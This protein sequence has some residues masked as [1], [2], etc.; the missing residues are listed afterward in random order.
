VARSRTGALR[1]RRWGQRPVVAPTTQG[2]KCK[3]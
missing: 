1:F 3:L 2:A